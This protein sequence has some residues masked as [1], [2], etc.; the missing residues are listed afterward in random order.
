MRNVMSSGFIKFFC[1]GEREGSVR[2]WARGS[3]SSSQKP[4]PETTE[5]AGRGF[6]VSSR[7]RESGAPQFPEVPHQFAEDRDTFQEAY[8][9]VL[10]QFM[11][12]P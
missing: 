3:F 12:K 8:F 2:R 5:T 4:N 6:G 10:R 11:L 1:G 9:R 7:G